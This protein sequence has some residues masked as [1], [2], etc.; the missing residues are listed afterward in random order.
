MRQRKLGSD[1]AMARSVQYISFVGNPNQNKNTRNRSLD[2]FRDSNLS[3]RP[4]GDGL[5]SANRPT[6][7][8]MPIRPGRYPQ[9]PGLSPS[10]G[11]EF[12]VKV[13]WN[14]SRWRQFQ[15]CNPGGPPSLDPLPPCFAECVCCRY[16]AEFVGVTC[17]IF[18]AFARLVS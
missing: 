3:C 8:F 18:L 1:F 14:E 5:R 12:R 4:E 11:R 2:C 7:N 10:L 16:A 17:G 13:P 6:S 15:L 9:R